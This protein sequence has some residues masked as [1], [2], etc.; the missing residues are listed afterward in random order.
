MV[1][2]DYIETFNWSGA[3]FG[4]S[5]Y[6]WYYTN[7]S[8]S[9]STSAA[10]YG[11][12]S[13]TSAIEQDWYVLP[14][15]TGLNPSYT[16][17]FKVRV[18]SYTFSNPTATSRGVDGSDL[19][20]IQ[21]STNGGVTYVSEIRVTGN[22]NAT[23]N[24]NTNGVISKTSNGLLTAYSPAGG[25]NRTTTGDGYSNIT[26]TLSGISQIAVDILC[27]VNAN[28]EEWW[29]DNIELIE[30]FPC[31]PLPIELIFFEGINKDEYIELNWVTATELN[32]DYFVLERSL[33]GIDWEEV[34]R[35]SG[36]GTTNTPTHYQYNDYYYVKGKINYYKL[37]Q[38]DYNG[39]TETFNIIFVNP[40]NELKICSE[41]EYYDLLGNVIDFSSVPPGI[42]LRRCGDKIEKILK[43]F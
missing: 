20:E 32:N 12:G 39:E 8:V 9:P 1:A 18:G 25:G 34:K 6:S 33:N 43:I 2:Y 22:N 3:W 38:V 27:R 42:Y 21:V 36:S 37:S 30:I 4:N 7:T 26:L 41:Y 31:N 16:Y 5:L 10:I 14:N 28:G 19:M 35:V 24:Y 15:I 40:K 23:W 17:Q 11:N 13:G 29:L